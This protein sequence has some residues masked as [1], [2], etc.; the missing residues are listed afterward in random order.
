MIKAFDLYSNPRAAIVFLIVPKER[1]VCDQQALISAMETLRPNIRVHLKTFENLVEDLVFD[2]S[3]Q[4]ISL[5]STNEEIAL[6]YFRAGYVPEHLS[7]IH[8]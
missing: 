2:A 1:N 3:T 4:N 8:I 5:R 6:V 7:L